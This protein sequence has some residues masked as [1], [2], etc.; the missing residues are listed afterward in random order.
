MAKK[1]P[2][3]AVFGTEREGRGIGNESEKYKLKVNSIRLDLFG[4]LGKI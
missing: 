1:F 2:Q 3:M 4:K